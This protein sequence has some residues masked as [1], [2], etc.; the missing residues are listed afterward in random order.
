MVDLWP[1]KF[2][3][4]LTPLIDLPCKGLKNLGN[5]L[6]GDT[7]SAAERRRVLM[8]TQTAADAR[9]IESGDCVFTNGELRPSIPAISPLHALTMQK[10]MDNLS[11]NLNIA[12]E[13]L[14]D[15]PDTEISDSEIEPDWFAR[16]R[17]GAT[18]IGN[19]QMKTLWGRILAEEIKSPNTFSYRTL[20]VLKNTTREDAEK[21]IKAAR[22]R[23]DTI[24]PCQSDD[25]FYGMDFSDTLGLIDSG[26]INSIKT[27]HQG[28]LQHDT[29]RD[30][31][32]NGVLFK[33]HPITVEETTGI[34]G[35]SIS[36]AGLDILTIAELQEI[37][38]DEISHIIACF[39]SITN[40]A[41]FLKKI[42]L[43]KMTDRNAY[44]PIP[45]DTFMTP[46][47]AKHTVT[48]HKLEAP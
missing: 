13:I 9:K 29:S 19:P 8:T 11:G 10:D 15:T 3:C 16:W 46:P 31:R 42:T 23:L 35:F 47:F 34:L 22:L 45:F 41:K 18:V 44:S 32:G 37:N 25:C 17:Q 2:S 4:D 30:L 20:D 5:L 40:N 48:F 24:I 28:T 12:I 43:H 14:K 27:I 7:L 26:L 33:T 21:F 38:H 36:R 1:V 6:F 39:N